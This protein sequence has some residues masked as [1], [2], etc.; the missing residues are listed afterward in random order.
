M[1][2]VLGHVLRLSQRPSL[3]HAEKGFKYFEP[4]SWTHAWILHWLN[5]LIRG[6]R[7][8]AFAEQC[9]SHCLM[10]YAF[11]RTYMVDALDR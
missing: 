8:F 3:E 11:L 4:Q 1:F 7:S 10:E 6:A 2:C 5:V 9:H